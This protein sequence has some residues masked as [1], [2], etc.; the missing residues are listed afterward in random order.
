[1]ARLA[2]TPE[3]VSMQK[4]AVESTRDVIYKHWTSRLSFHIWDRLS[5]SRSQ[6]EMLRHLLSFVFNP[7]AGVH[8]ASRVA[9]LLQH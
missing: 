5:L 7:N 9:R 8:N 6:M 4:A 3:F 2:D 1:M